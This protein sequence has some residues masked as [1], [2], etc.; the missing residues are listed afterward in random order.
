MSSFPSFFVCQFPL[1]QCRGCRCFHRLRLLF[2][3][4]NVLAVSQSTSPASK[5]TSTV[6]GEAFL[7]G[8]TSH[9]T[10]TVFFVGFAG[11]EPRRRVRNIRVFGNEPLEIAILGNISGRSINESIIVSPVNAVFL[12]EFLDPFQ[13]QASDSLSFQRRHR[14]SF[15]QSFLSTDSRHRRP[16]P[17]P[18]LMG[19]NC[20]TR[21]IKT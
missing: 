11:A 1:F 12:S 18:G 2:P 7:H 10:C 5:P 19:Q 9:Q 16:P 15:R 4:I 20:P 14:T 17:Q 21:P 13:T 8:I 6:F 3:P